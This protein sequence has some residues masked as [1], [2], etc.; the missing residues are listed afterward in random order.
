MPTYPSVTT[1]LRGELGGLLRGV[2]FAV[3]TDI[4]PANVL[5]RHVLHVEPDIVTRQ[6]LAERLVV[7]FHRLHLRGDVDWR[8]GHH[9]TRTEDTGL[10]SAHRY[11]PNAWAKRGHCEVAGQRRGA[12]QNIQAES[13]KVHRTQDLLLSDR[14]KGDSLMERIS[15]QR[16]PRQAEGE[17]EEGGSPLAD[18][19]NKSSQDSRIR[20]RWRVAQPGM[21]LGLL[22]PSWDSLNP[23]VPQWLCRCRGIWP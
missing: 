6:G 13:L 4:A 7:H 9:H 17:T 19:G 3:P 21:A 11:S 23:A 12:G 5:D 22:L 10:H 1:N 15:R 8:K 18:S 2:S 20:D 16:V 14:A